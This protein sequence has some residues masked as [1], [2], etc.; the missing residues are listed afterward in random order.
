[1]SADAP[2]GL[3]FKRLLIVFWTMFFTL[4]ALTN[5]VDLLD[6]L[7]AFDWR[8]LDS[9]NY[10]YLRSVVKAYDV[11]PA[12]TKVMLAGAFAIE[13]VAAVLF[14]RA[15][16]ALGRDGRGMREAFVAVCFGTFVWIAFVFM[17]EFFTAY[18]SESVFRELLAIMIGTALALVLVRDDATLAAAAR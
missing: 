10:D 16:S 17:T 11:G 12:L 15:L 5:L 4:V 2:L 6:E 8:F 1:V 18:Q 3:L 13:L 7:G 14:W 9:G